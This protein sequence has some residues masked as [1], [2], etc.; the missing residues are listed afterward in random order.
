MLPFECA[1]E[2][3]F[4]FNVISNPVEKDDIP[5]SL[6]GAGN[7]LVLIVM[8]DVYGKEVYAKQ[9][10]E[11]ADNYIYSIKTTSPIAPGMYTIIAS[12]DQKYISKKV[13]VK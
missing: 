12:N 5:I 1:E 3:L 10:I 13:L 7:K 4:G 8:I 6:T 11:N 2:Q 9:T